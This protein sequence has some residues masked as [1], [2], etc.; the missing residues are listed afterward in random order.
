MKNKQIIIPIFALFFSIL[1]VI[2]VQAAEQNFVELKLNY[3]SGKLALVESNV[4]KGDYSNLGGAY[5]AKIISFEEKELNQLFFSIPLEII[6]DVIDPKTGLIIGGNTVILNQLNFSLYIPYYENAKEVEIY[7]QT[8]LKILTVN[9]P[10]F[11]KDLCGDNLCQNW[12]SIIKCPSDCAKPAVVKEKAEEKPLEKVA[13]IVKETAS[14]PWF[15][16]ILVAI[17]TIIVIIVL[18]VKSK[19]EESVSQS[20]I[21]TNLGAEQS[22]FYLP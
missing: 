18:I 9:I 10:Q 12:E 22:F 6:N 20:E 5:L 21:I 16:V 14:S 1:F 19:K 11:S 13:A 15:W 2:P 4:I 8:G 3:N 17:V 7:N